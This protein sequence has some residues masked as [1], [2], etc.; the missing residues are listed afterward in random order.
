MEEWNFPWIES[1]CFYGEN[2]GMYIH[3]SL[4]RANRPTDILYEEYISGWKN[5]H[6]WESQVENEH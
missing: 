4:I 3:V 5:R 1:L 2:I 6:M